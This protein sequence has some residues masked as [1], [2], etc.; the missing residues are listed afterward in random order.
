MSVDTGVKAVLLFQHNFTPFVNL[1]L[2]MFWYIFKAAGDGGQAVVCP[3]TFSLKVQPKHRQGA[4]FFSSL[5]E[6][7]GFMQ[8]S[9]QINAHFAYLFPVFSVP[10]F[11]FLCW[12]CRLLCRY[13]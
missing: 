4:G 13:P 12:P 11:S 2:S 6:K 9:V 7:T 1:S 5:S 10:V 8:G 3:S